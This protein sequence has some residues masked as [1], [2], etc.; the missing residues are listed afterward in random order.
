MATMWSEIKESSL[1][2]RGECFCSIM[3]SREL[4]SNNVRPDR[5][6]DVMYVTFK[7]WLSSVECWDSDLGTK[8]SRETCALIQY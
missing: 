1:R 3:L 7:Q 6:W 4:K 2:V 8:E 5:A